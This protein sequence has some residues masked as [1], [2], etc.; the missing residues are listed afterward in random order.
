MATRIALIGGDS[1]IVDEDL[2]DVVRALE[3]HTP[4]TPAL[5]AFSV[6][7]KRVHVRPGA[8]AYVTSA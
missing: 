3:G 8:V 4:G 5:P 7:G 2:D 1:V 6:D